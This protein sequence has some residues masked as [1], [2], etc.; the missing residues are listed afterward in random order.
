MRELK[1]SGVRLSRIA[2][3]VPAGSSIE[4][5]NRTILNDALEGRTS[6]S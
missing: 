4:Y 2:R 5:S 1:E 3:G 6:L